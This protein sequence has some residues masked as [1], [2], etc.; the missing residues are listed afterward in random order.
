MI[1]LKKQK[2]F[3]LGV[4]RCIQA[5]VNDLDLY[6]VVLRSMIPHTKK[7]SQ[8][9]TKLIVEARM[10]PAMLHELHAIADNIEDH[11]RV[12]RSLSPDEWTALGARMRR[13]AVLWEAMSE[14]KI[15]GE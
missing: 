8:A 12:D 7:G 10:I 11:L 4:R 5:A 14:E 15:L 9:H 6:H 1:S 3:L 13:Q 2:S